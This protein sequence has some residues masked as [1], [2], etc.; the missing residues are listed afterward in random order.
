[1]LTRIRNA[2]LIGSFSVYVLQTNMTLAISK[3]LK[4]EGFIDSFQK[5]LVHLNSKFLCIKLKYKDSNRHKP[6]ITQ[7]L[8]V[9]KS[10]LRVYK[11][12]S[13]IPKVLGGIGVAIFVFRFYLFKN[14]FSYIISFIVSNYSL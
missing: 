2:S 9:S 3:V 13:N 14:Y 10:G 5:D 8:R 6:Y 11:S 4:E 7:L 12:Y 1:M